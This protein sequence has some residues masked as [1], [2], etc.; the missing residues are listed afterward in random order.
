MFGGGSLAWTVE[1]GAESCMRSIADSSLRVG[2]SA[3]RGALLG[4]AGLVGLRLGD[5]LG[6]AFGFAFG[7]DLVFG[8]GDFFLVFAGLVPF[9]A[10]TEC[11]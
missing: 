3:L 2:D 10:M 7:F 8:A 1:P 11:T 4:A 5:C 9:L 6:L